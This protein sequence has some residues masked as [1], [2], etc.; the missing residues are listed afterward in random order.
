MIH[1]ETLD[2]Q[3]NSTVLQAFIAYDKSH[4]Q[5]RPCVLIAHAWRGRDEFV[6]EKAK[7]LAKLGYVGVAM[8]VYGKG[9]LGD[10]AET[11]AKLMKPLMDDRGLLQKRLLRGMEAATKI[12][13]VDKNKMAAIGYCFGGLCALDMA[14]SGADLKGVVSFH[15][16]LQRDAKS[17]EKKIVSK[18]LVL[19]GHDDPMVSPEMV[20]QFEEEMT[21]A[22]VDWQIH[23]YSNTMH[24]FTN[25]QVNDPN[26]GTVY[27][28]VAD[29]RSWIAMKNFL[30]EIFT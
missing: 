7:A 22:K 30:E 23:I 13:V 11:N 28:P 2:Y 29:K 10:G 16:L 6:D 8:D 5:K 19:H 20:T 24:A 1:T 27:N 18:V 4:S 9:V 14:R 25:P 12:P 17:S 3:D 15:G 26:F 21:Q